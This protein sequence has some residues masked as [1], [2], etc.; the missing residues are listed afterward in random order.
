MIVKNT[1]TENG[2]ASVQV[3]ID[4]VAFEN[5]LNKAYQKAKKS[6]AIPGWRKGKAPRKMV[7]AMYGKDVF[8][9]DAIEEIFPDLYT[10]AIVDQQLKAVGR[11]WIASLNRQ[12]DGSVLVEVATDLYPEVKL[13]QYKGLEVTKA[14]VTVTDEEV[15]AELDRMVEQNAA[16]STVER[17]AQMGDTVVIDFDGYVNGK[18]FDGGKAENYELKLGSGAFIPG[19]EDQLVGLEAGADKDVVVTFPEQY[20]PELAGKEATFRCKVHEVKETILPAKDDEFA[21][22]VSEFDTLEELR[23]DLKAKA[24]KQKEDGVQDAFRNAC[25][26]KAVEGMEVSVPASMVEEQLDREM[27]SFG[28]QIE[29][30]GMTMQDYARMM[31]GE[32]KMRDM[33]RGVAENK[34]KS[35]LLIGQVVIEEGITASDEEVEAE[36]AAMAEQYGMEVEKVKE[37]VSAEDVRNELASRKAAELIVDS[38]IAVKPEPVEAKTEE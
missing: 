30:S 29:R 13:G 24:L 38:A 34:V 12:E 26:A 3:E 21:K 28:Y 8:V 9:E 35:Q 16:I 1:A 33:F 22:D 23:A 11:P 31:G 4:A 14:E 15:E 17:E 10:A 37:Y 5:A 32:D 19:F 6:I 25:V 20:T 27:E 7:E 2:K 18:Q 36:Y